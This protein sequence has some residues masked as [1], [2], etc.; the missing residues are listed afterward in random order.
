MIRG[1]RVFVSGGAGVI[2]RELVPRLLQAGAS[3]LVGDIKPIPDEFD[4]AV[5]YRQGDLN[6]LRRQELESFQ[7]NCFVHLA[8]SLE[9]TRETYEFWDESYWNNVR[10]SHYLMT[11][12]KEL[13]TM[14][15]VLFASS[16]LLYDSRQY[17]FAEPRVE[18]VLLEESC[19]IA[20]RGLTGMAK[21]AHEVELKFL[22]GFRETSFP[23]L[24][25]R[26]FRG[27]GKGS[28]DI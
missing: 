10:L 28:G 25:V 6:Y 1:A 13:P 26:I 9:R 19:A 14:R 16:Y 23:T 12:V 8:A 3:V 24:R 5:R 18:P 22:H 2:G 11:L 4:P 27:Y 21:R 17:Q 20:P 7:P 15:R